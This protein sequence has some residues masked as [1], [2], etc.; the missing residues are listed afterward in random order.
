[1]QRR[2]LIPSDATHMENASTKATP[3][4]DVAEESPVTLS[5]QLP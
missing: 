5:F 2:V 1:V 4:R 3:N